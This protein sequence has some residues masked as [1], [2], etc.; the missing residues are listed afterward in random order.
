MDTSEAKQKHLSE[1]LDKAD[2]CVKTWRARLKDTPGCPICKGQLETAQAGEKQARDAVHG[3]K[4]VDQQLEG[5]SKSVNRLKLES[6]TEGEAIRDLMGKMAD[7]QEQLDKLKLSFNRRRQKIT[8]TAAKRDQLQRPGLARAAAIK[9]Q[10]DPVHR[11]PVP[12]AA[13]GD[14]VKPQP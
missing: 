14:G 1:Q 9:P 7:D 4:T 8:E 6:D 11:S 13:G 10:P 3:S 2:N 12:A 5:L